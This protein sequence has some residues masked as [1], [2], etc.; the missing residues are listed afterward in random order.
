MLAPDSPGCLLFSADNS[1]HLR[2]ET[3]VDII[4]YGY[5]HDLFGVQSVHVAAV[6]HHYGKF[7]VSPLRSLR[8]K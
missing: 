4:L 3:S 5:F 8:N 2:K 7:F 1:W 6:C